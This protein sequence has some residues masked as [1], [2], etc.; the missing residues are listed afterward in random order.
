MT[1]QLDV[2]Q[3]LRQTRHDWLN[4]MQLIKGNLALK[5][6]DRIEEI[7]HQVTQQSICESKIS[8]IQAPSVVY[9]LLT[10]NW[11]SNNIKLELDVAGEVFSLENKEVQLLRLCEEITEKLTNDCTIDTEN[12]LLITFL[13]TEE[14]CEV[15]FDFQGALQ[16]KVDWQRFKLERESIVNLVEWNEQECVLVARFA[17]S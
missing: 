13:F 16:K 17:R 11:F 7:I 5:R 2:L 9:F 4:V 10:Y 6:Y 14:Y 1:N 8:E 15:T 12:N 3:A